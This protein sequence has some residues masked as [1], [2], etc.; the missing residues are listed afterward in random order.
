MANVDPLSLEGMGEIPDPAAHLAGV[1]VP[2]AAVPTQRSL[3]RDDRR[4]RVRAVSLVAVA[5][6]AAALALFGVR[7]DIASIGVAAPIVAW[8][9]GGAVVLGVVL[10]PR[11]RGLP[12][13][14]RAVQHAIWVVPAAYVLVAAL[15]AA[16][17]EGPL[18]WASIRGCLCLS[19]VMALGPL[20]AGA[21]LLRGA[22]PSA[23]GWRG[24]AVGGLLGLAGSIGVHA[25]C[26]VQGLGHLLAAHGATIAIAAVAGGALGCLG[27]RP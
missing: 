25:H 11:E 26:P 2:P 5:W 15:V 17:T 6:V 7:S 19:S 21:L 14:V 4:V 16:P 10:R 23:P 18:T 9:L 27:G 1:A 13:G 8:V 24:A 20:V 3:T 22:F 12:A